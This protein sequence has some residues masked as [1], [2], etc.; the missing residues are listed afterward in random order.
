MLSE[1]RLQRDGEGRKHKPF[2]YWLRCREQYFLPDLPPLEPLGRVA[3]T[4][5]E[6]ETELMKR[7][8]EQGMEE[9]RRK[10]SLKETHGGQRAPICV[11]GT[12]CDYAGW[13]LRRAGICLE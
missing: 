4:T 6:E 1:G 2:R 12:T 9:K 3:E 5:E 11:Q 10:K 13:N 7:I 8:V